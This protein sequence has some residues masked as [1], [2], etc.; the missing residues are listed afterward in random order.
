MVNRH[1]KLPSL[2]ALAS[3][4]AVARHLNLTRASE[5]LNVTPG[6]VSKQLRQLEAELGHPLIRRLSN[7]VALT[8]EGEAVAASL[9]DAF[10]RIGTTLQQVRAAGEKGHVS[11]LSSMATM[12][13]WL[14]PRLGSF[15]SDHQDIVVEHVIS[16]RQHDVPRPDIDLRIRYGDGIWPGEE[17]EKIQG[18][19]VV[20]VASP[21]FLDRHP[22]A[23]MTELAAAPLLSVEGEDWVWMTWGR[24]LRDTGTVFHKLNV[25]RFNSYVIALQAARNGQGVSLGWMSLVRPLIASG[26][27][28][29]VTDAEVSDPNAFYVTWNGRKDL[30]PE[31]LPLKNWLLAQEF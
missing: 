30:G 14:M 22:I 15:W 18:D 1:Y 25:R 28:C 31:A 23:T 12:Q 27:L 13:L 26:E 8:A 9:H 11:V 16:D 4:E 3:F 20:A 5:E 21:E 24:F 2:K 29:Q 10:E 7:G 19:K 17:A 6:A